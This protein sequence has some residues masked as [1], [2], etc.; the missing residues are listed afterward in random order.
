MTSWLWG[1]LGAL[2]FR[3]TTMWRDWQ[4]REQGR[5]EE[6]LEQLENIS[7]RLSGRPRTPLD[8]KLRIKKWKDR[9]KP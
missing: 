8:V 3:L 4:S 2:A 1:L 7:D 5:K 6:R 9:I